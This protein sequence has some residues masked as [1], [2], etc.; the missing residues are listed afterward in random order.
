M[1]N[2]FKL[3]KRIFC[4]FIIMG[5][6]VLLTGCLSNSNG[7]E[8]EDIPTQQ[9]TVPNQNIT[10]WQN[11][12]WYIFDTVSY[13]YSYKGDEQTEFAQYSNEAFDLLTEYHKLFDIYHEYEGIINLCTINKNAGKDA[14][15]VDQKLIDFLIY[16]KQVYT[17]TKGETNVML[18][19]VLKLWHDARETASNKPSEKYIP[20]LEA[21]QEANLYTSIELLEIDD[22]KN[23]VRI[24]HEK[25]RIDVGALGKGYATEKAA[26]YLESVG[27]SSYV[28]NIGGNIRIIG[29]KPNG[30]GWKTGITNPFKDPN[31]PHS[32]IFT[33]SDTSCV[34]SGDYERFFVY[35]GKKYHHII[36]KDTLMPSEHFASV[37]ILAKDSGLAD[38]LS[39][40]LFA[41]S[42]DEG[43]AIVD[44]I[45]NVEVV[46]I[47]KDG[48]IVYTDGVSKLL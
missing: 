25:G 13:I 2:K 5:Q 11:Q 8:N 14:M 41:M 32:L 26:Q 23:T 36:D 22:E 42:Y 20:S 37:T 28:L 46:W 6:L 18:G 27:C 29:K 7:N 15:I 44:S 3:I 35:N 1:E 43:K 39:T 19:P 47:Y 21:L 31:K 38:A 34:T 17:I 40:A 9:P 48:T 33:I 10:V 24:A 16:A 12:N 30:A 4:L 45:A